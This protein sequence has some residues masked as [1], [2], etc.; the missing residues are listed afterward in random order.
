MTSAKKMY[1]AVAS[2]LVA[3]GIVLAALGFA[4]SGFNPQV[5]TT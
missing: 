5:F 2:G 3:A 4:L 1:F